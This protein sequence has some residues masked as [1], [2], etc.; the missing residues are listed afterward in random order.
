MNTQGTDRM[1]FHSSGDIHAGVDATQSLGVAFLKWEDLVLLNAP[2]VTSDERLKTFSDGFVDAEKRVAI[3]LK[4]L[5]TTYKWNK[6][7]VRE[8][9]G[10][11][12]ARIHIGLGAQSLGQAFRDEGLDPST[13]SMF[14]Y[15]EWED[16]LETVQTNKGAVT[17]TP[18]EA[19]VQK[20]VKTI[21]DVKSESV[22]L[23][24]GN[25]TLVKKITPTEVDQPTYDI[26][27]VYNGEGVQIMERVTTKGDDGKEVISN[28]PKTISIPVM[29]SVIIDVETKDTP[30]YE[31][32]VKVKA[33][34]V[35]GIKLEEVTLFILAN[36]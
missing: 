25:Y 18:T 23:I 27:P 14:H 29:E 22:E 35:F 8:V 7:I 21:V 34:N 30:I 10:G 16:I 20:T 36:T 24:N 32:V 4:S 17:I 11:N 2:T 26:H 3:A 12:P 6:S 9:E 31:E 19:E 1:T 13:Y 15:D 5:V 33:G 28:V